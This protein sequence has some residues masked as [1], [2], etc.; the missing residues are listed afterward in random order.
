MITGR[1]ITIFSREYPPVIVGGT[2]LVTRNLAVGLARHGWQVAVVTADPTA[3]I[4]RSEDGDGVTVLR[5]G[6][7]SVYN[8]NSGL[9]D[10][11]LRTHRQLYDAARRLTDGVGPPDIVALPDL[12]CYPEASLFARAHGVPLINILLQD[13]RAITPY[14]PGAHQ[15]TSGVS[16][17]HAH[18]M[19]IERKAL[20]GSDLTVFIS[21]ALRDSITRQY[22]TDAF[23][24]KVVHL[25][26]DLEEMASTERDDTRLERRDALLAATPAGPR[27]P[28]VVAC[29]RLVPVKGFTQLITALAGLGPVERPASGSTALPHLV[30][31]GS[32]PQ[33]QPLLRLAEERGVADRVTL[34]GGL[35]RT[36][37]LGWMSVADVAV[38]PSVWESF[39]YV[40]AEML[41]LG[42]PVVA[43]A[44]DSLRELIPDGRYGYPVPVGGPLGHRTLDPGALAH[45]L[46]SALTDPEQAAARGGAGRRRIAKHF[47]NERFV[48]HMSALAAGLV[49]ER[50]LSR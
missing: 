14:D 3:G 24:H 7:G 30:L 33:E 29:G 13:F 38:V 16:S 10:D 20:L 49:Q 26:V 22:G 21:E 6:T 19:D 46:R 9:S 34:L 35:P 23:R 32:G 17:D 2:S 48:I 28:L 50:G 18:L 37:V 8:A 40:C 1:R 39:C 44:V 25:G 45:A 27:T 43:S 47:T 36:T 12:F 41:A 4:E 15:V 42:R 31:L 5:V 11:S